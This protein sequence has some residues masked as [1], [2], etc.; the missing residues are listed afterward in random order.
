MSRQGVAA[1]RDD[2][3][4]TELDGASPPECRVWNGGDG[5]SAEQ[6]CV[7]A[8]PHRRHL[9][10]LA[11]GVLAAPVW[12]AMAAP[13]AP[14][15][16]PP[17]SAVG[18][19]FI[20]SIAV[21]ADY[22]RSGLVVATGSLAPC[23]KDCVRLWVSRDG[24]FSWHAAKAQ[25]WSLSRIF[26]AVD[27]HGHEGIF[28]AGSGGILRSDDDGNS[29]LPAG[30]GGS[31]TVLPSYARDGGVVVAST[32]SQGGDY[33]L[34]NSGS[35]AVIGS[36]G[37][38]NDLHYMVSPDFPA[39]GSYSPALLVAID[40]HTRQA[41]VLHCT[42]AFSCTGGAG[43]PGTTTDSRSSAATVLY[44]AGDYAQTGTVFAQTP[45][46]ID[47]STDGGQAF[48]PVPVLPANGATATVTPAFALAD[49]YRE[50]GPV[51][52]A[53]VAVLQSFV[54]PMPSSVDSAPGP[55]QVA[56][57]NHTSGGVYRSNDGGSSWNPVVTSG[58][59]AGGAIALAVAPDG[60]IFAAYLDGHGDQGLLCSADGGAS[61]HASCPAVG[62]HARH[63]SNGAGAGGQNAANGGSGDAVTGAAAGGAD[64]NGGGSGDGTG[65]PAAA[66]P[67]AA[68]GSSHGWWP[69][70][71]LAVAVCLGLASILPHTRPRWLSSRR[72]AQPD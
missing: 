17:P 71:L 15:P 60:R 26:L 10:S 42:A 20:Q 68:T 62:V 41:R 36:G 38:A 40:S 56:A 61:W 49:G 29:W 12:I 33:L 32:S 6:R 63:R 30:A 25:G 55:S 8:R 9:A 19:A 52:T 67:D 31:P 5:M 47:K 2:R 45:V 16:P 70:L 34:R 64:N 14:T 53:Y 13:P 7:E 48:L 23:S 66:H 46:G 50:S 65:L 58:P 18:Q 4:G 11:L 24:G 51:R 69:Y 72:R 27:A 59:F 44:P 1:W 28:S 22:A 37:T 35:S 57:Q 43:L 3:A 39:S 54:T 21:S